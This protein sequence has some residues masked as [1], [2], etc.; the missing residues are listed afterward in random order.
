MDFYTLVTF[1]SGKMT[2]KANK[3]RKFTSQ[4]PQSASISFQWSWTFP[5]WGGGQN[6]VSSLDELVAT[7]KKRLGEGTWLNPSTSIDDTYDTDEPMTYE[8]R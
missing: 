7:S 5:S 6:H 8:I 4:L 3:T 1:W 2:L